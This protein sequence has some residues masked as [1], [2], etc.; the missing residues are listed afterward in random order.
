[1]NILLLFGSKKVP[2]LRVVVTTATSFIMAPITNLISSASLS[3][4][5]VGN[6]ILSIIS[7]VSESFVGEPGGSA[8]DY[9]FSG[10]SLPSG[11]TLTRASTGTYFNSSGVLSSASSDTARFDYN[12][13][14]LALRGLLIEPQQTNLLTS[15]NTY[16]SISGVTAT[17]DYATSPDGTTN[18]FGIKETATTDRHFTYSTKSKTNTVFNISGACFKPDGRNYGGIRVGS[19]DYRRAIYNLTTGELT[20]TN[21]S[22]WAASNTGSQLLSNGFV[23]LWARTSVKTE[24]TD[25]PCFFASDV[26]VPSSFSSYIPSYAGDD[27]KGLILYGKQLS[28]FSTNTEKL[29]S[30]ILTSG[31]TATR[32]ADVLQ[33]TIPSGISTLRYTFDDDSTQDVSVSAGSYTVPTDLNRAW[34]KRIQSV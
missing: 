27:T 25:I 4:S 30:L 26:A 13:S 34:I 5:F 1:M 28:E 23:F 11:V 6:P 15:S 18:A 22:T 32:S 14:T 29:G 16:D 10:G 9:S 2:R 33:F 17:N 21:D 7:S 19:S 31:A 12:P 20:E 3:Q 8:L 24:T